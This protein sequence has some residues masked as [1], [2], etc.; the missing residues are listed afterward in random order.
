M[1]VDKE[2]MRKFVDFDI[3]S[4]VKITIGVISLLGR[5]VDTLLKKELI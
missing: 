3:M 5:Q 2:F 4:A 1:Q